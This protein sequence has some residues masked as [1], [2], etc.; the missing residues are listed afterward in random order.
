MRKLHQ[1]YSYPSNSDI[2]DICVV[3]DN[4]SNDTNDTKVVYDVDKRL[5]TVN[6]TETT[7]PGILDKTIIAIEEC[8]RLFDFD[9]LVRSNMST[10]IDM[11]NLRTILKEK[12]NNNLYGGHVWH[13]DYG[14][15]F[16]S[17]ANIILSR[18]MCETL[19][20]NKGELRRDVMDDISIGNFFKPRVPFTDVHFFNCYDV[21]ETLVK[22]PNILPHIKSA[23]FF[24]NYCGIKDDRKTDIAN[25]EA[26]YKFIQK[27]F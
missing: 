9:I 27:F 8:L 5:I 17:G 2:G 23:A 19:V 3:Y 12:Y 14:R 20:K 1:K 6:G 13:S 10:V 16:V 4:C 18:T 11:N 26:Q 21:F 15:V 22:N 25:I 7:V 24:R